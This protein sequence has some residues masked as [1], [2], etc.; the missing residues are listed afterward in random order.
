MGLISSVLSLPLAPIRGVVWIAER[1]QDRA[2]EE[3][4]GE[5][6]IRRKLEE[7]EMAHD[8]DEITDEE[9]EQIQDELLEQLI[10]RR[11]GADHE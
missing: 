6:A 4:F 1:I 5:G 3:A 2:E 8:L 11:I 10:E 9:Y 7:L